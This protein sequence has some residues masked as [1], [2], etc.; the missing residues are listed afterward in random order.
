VKL[1]H[2]ELARVESEKV[3]RYLLN[4]EHP[5]G[6]QK[7][8]FFGRF[9]FERDGWQIFAASLL[10]HAAENPVVRESVTA[11]GTS[12]VVEGKLHCPDGRL[13]GVRAVWIIDRG[14]DVPRL[15]TAYP[16]TRRSA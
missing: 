12:Y 14:S 11:H 6:G 3:T 8:A 7:A 2:L 13:P 10:R 1:P 4:A 15:V 9:G 5:E 16:L